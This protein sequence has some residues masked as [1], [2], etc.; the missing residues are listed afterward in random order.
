MNTMSLMNDAPVNDIDQ[1]LSG[2]LDGIPADQVRS[3]MAFAR[4]I[5]RQRVQGLSATR[6][7]TLMLVPNQRVIS[8]A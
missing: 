8:Q 4:Q 7:P 6:K 5:E 3:L 1:I 2:L